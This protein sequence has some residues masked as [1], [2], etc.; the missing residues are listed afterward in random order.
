MFSQSGRGF[1]EARKSW[2]H[3]QLAIS[4]LGQFPNLQTLRFAPDHTILHLEHRFAATTTNVHM[5]GPV[6]VAVEEELVSVLLEYLRHRHSLPHQRHLGE[7]IPV[8]R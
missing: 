7:D 4:G 2:H 6:L 3:S 1:A 5:D 8:E